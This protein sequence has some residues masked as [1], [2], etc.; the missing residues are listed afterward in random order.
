MTNTDLP[1]LI[2]RYLVAYNAF[3]VES[4]LALLSQ[5]VVFENF[6][7]DQLTASTKGADQFRELAQ[8]SATMFSER[9]QRVTGV[10]I[11]PQSTV[12]DIAYRGRLAVDVPD[13]PAAGTVLDLKGQSEFWFKDGLISKIVDR[14]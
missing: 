9:E 10:T 1:D 11:Q 8:Q 6:L 14:S 2:E 3:D 12:V 5:D 4:M 7:G 13:G